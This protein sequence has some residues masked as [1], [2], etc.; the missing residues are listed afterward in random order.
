V[1]NLIIVGISAFWAGRGPKLA[2]VTQ[3]ILTVYILL[4]LY[5]SERVR[6]TFRDFS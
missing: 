2:D 4:Y 5:R 1:L 3:A 6:D